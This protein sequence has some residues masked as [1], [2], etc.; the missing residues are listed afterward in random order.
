M[1]NCFPTDYCATIVDENPVT[2]GKQVNFRG[3]RHC[4]ARIYG[5][6]EF[7]YGELLKVTEEDTR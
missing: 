2:W 1:K 6:V 7:K 5:T 4:T 3:T